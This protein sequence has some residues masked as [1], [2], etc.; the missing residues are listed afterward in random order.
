MSFL[1]PYVVLYVRMSGCPVTTGTQLPACQLG[2]D[3]MPEVS[4]TH[5]QACHTAT[6]NSADSHMDRALPTVAKQWKGGAKGMHG[7]MHEDHDAAAPAAVEHG[8]R[9]WFTGNGS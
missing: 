2:P 7:A 4:P 9:S 6:H 5:Q 8:P 1:R 3:I